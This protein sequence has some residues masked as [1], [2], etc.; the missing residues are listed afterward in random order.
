MDPLSTNQKQVFMVGIISSY[1]KS[2]TKFE[3]FKTILL[4]CVIVDDILRCYNLPALQE[5]NMMNMV[6]FLLIKW[7]VEI[8]NIRH[9]QVLL[10]FGSEKKNIVTLISDKIQTLERKISITD[11]III[12]IIIDSGFMCW[13]KFIRTHQSDK[14]QNLN[15]LILEIYILKWTVSWL[16]ILLP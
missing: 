2:L 13:D 8:Y 9:A 16:N 12:M 1:T 14:V 7:K 5:I 15:L 11:L 4:T 6:Q 3:F 10:Y